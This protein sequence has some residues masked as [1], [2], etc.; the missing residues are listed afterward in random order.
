MK[1]HRCKPVDLHHFYEWRQ[2][3]YVFHLQLLPLQKTIRI[4]VGILTQLKEIE[5]LATFNVRKVKR[6]ESEERKREEYYSV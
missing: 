3:P 2:K 5:N 6:T 4:E 1:K